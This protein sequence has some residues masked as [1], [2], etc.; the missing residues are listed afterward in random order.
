MRRLVAAIA[1]S[2]STAACASTPATSLDVPDIEGSPVDASVTL[3]HDFTPVRFDLEVMQR[4]VGETWV[5]E[6]GRLVPTAVAIEGAG[7]LDLQLHEVEGEQRAEVIVDLDGVVFDATTDGT[8]MPDG[9]ESDQADAVA[10]RRVTTEFTVDEGT[11][12]VTTD[13]P[14][15]AGVYVIVPGYGPAFPSGVLAPGDLWTEE[16]A[17]D[18]GGAAF[19][20]TAEHALTE[21]L[22]VDGRRVARVSTTASAADATVAYADLSAEELAQVIGEEAG[23]AA[24]FTDVTVRISGL[25]N[26]V[27]TWLDVDTGRVVRQE[28]VAGPVDRVTSFPDEVALTYF[29]APGAFESRETQEVRLLLD[30]SSITGAAG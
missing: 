23:L 14:F 6:E 9:A 8:A 25:R 20:V 27:T 30:D 7:E 10:R 22:D 28:L 2:L 12:V 26:E 4:N 19:Q 24:L 5:P 29:A 15:S 1:G 18:L 3:I 21:V 16:Y 17:V 11:S 13:Q